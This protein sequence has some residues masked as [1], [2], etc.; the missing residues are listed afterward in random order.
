MPLELG[1][2][3]GAKEFG[4]GDHREKICLILDKGQFRYQKFC[5]DIAGQDIASHDG[6]V[7]KLITEIR[8]WL[9]DSITEMIPTGG[10]IYDRYQSFREG[11]P[12]I[13]GTYHM[14]PEELTFVDFRNMVAFWLEGNAPEEYD[15]L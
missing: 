10:V 8:N 9:S 12:I 11:L 3:L 14:A 2:F 7:G 1:L 6:E 4:C 5:S 13:S 15:K